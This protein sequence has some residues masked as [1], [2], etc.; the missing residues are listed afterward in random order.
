MPDKWDDWYVRL[1]DL[2]EQLRVIDLYHKS[3][4]SHSQSS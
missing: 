4:E 1:T 3:G 2:K